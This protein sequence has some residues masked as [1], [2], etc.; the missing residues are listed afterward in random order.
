MFGSLLVWLAIRLLFWL[1][2]LGSKTT[3]WWI[4][5]FYFWDI[6]SMGGC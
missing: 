1:N 6:P 3:I 2:V 5:V 4:I